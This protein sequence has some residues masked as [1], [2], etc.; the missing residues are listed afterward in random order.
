MALVLNEVVVHFGEASCVI[1][2]CLGPVHTFS[3]VWLTIKLSGAPTTLPLA[4]YLRRVGFV[5]G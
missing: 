1:H 3:S 2:N 5:Q 4:K